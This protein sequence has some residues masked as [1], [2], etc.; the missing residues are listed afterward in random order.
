ME[1]PA[2]DAGNFSIN[3]ADDESE[4]Q[5]TTLMDIGVLSESEESLAVVNVILPESSLTQSLSAA[6]SENDAEEEVES[7][8]EDEE[9]EPKKPCS[10]CISLS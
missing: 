3:F 2:G 1:K 6:A 8:V 4:E 9:E 5:S 7:E 10:K